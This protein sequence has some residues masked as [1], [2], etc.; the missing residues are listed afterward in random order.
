MA[1]L[2]QGLIFTHAWNT[3][4]RR[5]A[6]IWRQKLDQ[7]NK[8]KWLPAGVKQINVSWNVGT[9]SIFLVHITK[10]WYFFNLIYQNNRNITITYI[11]KCNQLSI[12]AHNYSVKYSGY[13]ALWGHVQMRWDYSH[14]S[15]ILIFRVL[16]VW[17]KN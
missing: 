10:G 8:T 5:H 9:I 12:L 1:S 2:W 4:D 6:R 13:E 3:R 7:S 16:C 17:V 15:D 14:W 11:V